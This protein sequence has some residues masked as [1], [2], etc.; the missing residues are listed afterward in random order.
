MPL[1]AT[2]LL[3]IPMMP[4]LGIQPV[5][6][7]TVNYGNHLIFLFLGGFILAAGMQRWGL[8]RRIALS[9]VR[10]IGSTPSRIMLGFMLATAFLSMWI[11]NTATTVM[12]YAVGISV[13]EFVASRIEDRKLVRNFGVG[14]M[15]AIAFSASIGGVGTLIGTPPNA[16]LAGLL[17]DSYGVEIGFLQWMLIGVPVV[18]VMLPVCF[19]LLSRVIF[20][21]KGLDLRGVSAVI[22]EEHA[23]LGR[24]DRGEITVAL[25]FGAAAFFWIT[26]GFLGLPINDAGIAMAAALLLFAIPLGRKEGFV[27]DWSVA[28]SLPWGVLMLFGGGLALAGAF[29][30]T[31][32]AEWI[33]EQVAGLQGVNLWLLIL[34][35]ATVIV[36]LT[37]ITSNT[38]STATFLP[39]L[40]AVAVGLG[41]AP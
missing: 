41:V 32:L 31:G 7:I 24:M 23:R 19:L 4:L 8:H 5:A 28:R 9:I 26:R 15:L 16:L 33:G 2:A 40:G 10:A 13:I 21:M 18:L 39:I 20:P 27:L 11:S 22:A 17:S 36:Y 29:N 6:E 1:P 34:I 14:L 12:M 38:A 35:V 3:P 25:V 37:E 30:A